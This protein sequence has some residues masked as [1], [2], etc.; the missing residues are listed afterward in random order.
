MQNNPENKEIHSVK[1]TYI[2]MNSSDSDLI[3]ELELQQPHMAIF[4]H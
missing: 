3:Q 1:Q 2:A 4:F